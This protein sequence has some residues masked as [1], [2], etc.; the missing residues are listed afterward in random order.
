MVEEFLYQRMIHKHIPAAASCY[1]SLFVNGEDWGIYTN[2]QQTNAE[3]LTEWFMDNSG[4]RWRTDSPEGLEVL[5]VEVEVP[6]AAVAVAAL[7]VVAVLTGRRNGC[8]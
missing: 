4:A 5:E 8:T 6:A 7:V 1:F 3:F 2:V